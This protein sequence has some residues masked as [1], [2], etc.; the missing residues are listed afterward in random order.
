VIVAVSCTAAAV[1]ASP[2]A[3]HAGWIYNEA[4]APVRAAI[5]AAVRARMGA[6]VDVS[7]A[8]LRIREANGNVL[9][10]NSVL[11][12][13]P[14]VGAKTGGFVRFVLYDARAAG[15]ASRS[16]GSVT[17]RS[18]GR[19]LATADA[20]IFVTAEHVRARRAIDRGQTIA[21]DDVEATRED[22]GRVPLKPMPV[23]RAT[24]GTK[25]V[26]PIA[27]GER[28]A[29][30]MIRARALVKSGDAVETIARQGSLEVRGTAVATQTGGFGAEIRLVNTSSRRSFRGRVVAAGEVEVMYEH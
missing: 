6:G 1:M 22:V 3:A 23:V 24:I 30:A 7:V 21:A 13:I 5:I 26:Q 28:I 25:A 19:R 12:A 18:L 14:D 17:T 27:A 29:P 16:G 8:T 4:E 11:S 20:E 10:A 9:N 2:R 15:A